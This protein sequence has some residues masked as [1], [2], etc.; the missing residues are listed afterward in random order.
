MQIARK[1]EFN[2]KNDRFYEYSF[3]DLVFYSEKSANQVI[4]ANDAKD[5]FNNRHDIL[6][7]FNCKCNAIFH[8][9]KCEGFVDEYCSECDFQYVCPDCH[10]N[11]SQTKRVKSVYLQSHIPSIKL[12]S[13]CKINSLPFV[14]IFK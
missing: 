11:H 1:D 12:N 4:N 6:F 5:Y 14:K 8:C 9:F 10:P 7:K 13:W 2:V 3:K